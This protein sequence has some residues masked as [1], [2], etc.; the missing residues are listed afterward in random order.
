MRLARLVG[1]WLLLL[2]AGLLAA[3]TATAQNFPK[4]SGLV[5]DAA[6]VLPPATRDDLTKK[7]QAL[8]HDTHRQLVVA[9]IP[10][11]GDQPLE[12][13]GYKL[14][15]QWGVGL[16]DVNNG[17]ILFIAPNEPPGHRGPRIEVGTGLEPIVTDALSSVVINQQMMPKL[18]AGDVPGA[19]EAG[20]DA[21]IAQLRASPDEA[22][23]RTDAAVAQFN[24]THQHINGTTKGG[25]AA[26]LIFW[27]VCVGFI[28]ASWLRR[29]RGDVNH[30][31][32]NWPI[33]LWGLA[34][35]FENSRGG[36]GSGWSSGGGDSG[37]SSGGW[38]GSDFSGGGGGDFGGGGASGSW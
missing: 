2:L 13:Y 6:N 8:Q 24:T 23:A 7:L 18:R 4:F 28:A 3:S 10:S 17:I 9:T 20:T 34:S 30:R 38:G 25:I 19:M 26:G 11:L 16:R 21:L 1:T 27:I 32:G 29:G 35:A 33:M 15:R 5:V 12:D 14:G 36:G 22:K 37:G 31:G